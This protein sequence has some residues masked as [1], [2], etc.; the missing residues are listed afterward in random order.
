M[1]QDWSESPVLPISRR[2]KPSMDTA[3]SSKPIVEAFL[4]RPLATAR[5]TLLRRSAQDKRREEECRDTNRKIDDKD[6][7][8]TKSRT[9]V[10]TNGRAK[11]RGQQQRDV[12][13]GGCL[14]AFGWRKNAVDNR[15]RN[16]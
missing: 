13:E 2:V 11:G 12:D 6:G 9:Q 16:R 5:I 7:A 4:F 3:A 15:K 8:P 14:A 10:A 1:S